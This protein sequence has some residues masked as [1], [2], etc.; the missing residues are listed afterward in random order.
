MQKKVTFQNN[1]HDMAGIL[2][3]PDDFDETKQ[4]AAFPV[5][6]PAGAVKEQI[7]TN[8]G[9]R[10]AKYGFIAL[11]FDTSHQGESGGNPRQ[12]EAPYERVEDIKCAI[13]Y[14]TT[15]PYV[16]NERIGLFGV[17]AVAVASMS[18][19]ASWI[20]DGF[21]GKMPVDAQLALLEEAS[22]QRTREA[23]GADPIYGTFVPEE[24]TDGMP[25]TLEE[26]H[27]YYRTARGQHPR[28]TNQVSMMSIDKMTDFSTFLFADRYLTQPILMIA[29]TNAD[30]LRFSED[31]LKKAASKNKEL[32]T[33]EGATHVD[34]YDKPEYVD[35][36]VAKAATFFKENL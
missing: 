3:F 10:L 30:T 34:L 7:A 15:L 1:E 35:Q 17:C 11:V 14:L 13:D 26:A 28:S 12:L 6:S 5:A 19:P 27:E 8:Y 16:D 20:R 24:V 22:N 18:D 31:L 29:G 2:F 4:Y 32:F 33:I 9:S 21:D 23:N 25:N 36:A